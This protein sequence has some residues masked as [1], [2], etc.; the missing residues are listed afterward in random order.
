MSLFIRDWSVVS[1]LGIGRSEFQS[2]IEQRTEQQATDWTSHPTYPTL[3]ESFDKKKH[4]GKKGVRGMDQLGAYATTA[5]QLLSQ[6]TEALTDQDHSKVAVVLGTGTGS[7]KSQIEF[8][9]DLHV[10]ERVE[11]V[12]PI[13]FPQTVMNCAAGQVSIWH[14]FTGVNT[15]ISSGYQS[16]VTACEYANNLFGQ[17]RVDWALVGAAE[18]YSEYSRNMFPHASTHLHHDHPMGEGC[19]ML[20][21]SR[22]KQEHTV[23]EILGSQRFAWLAR[24]SSD[25]RS[26]TLSQLI[27]DALQKVAGSIPVNR[28]CFNAFSDD[29]HKVVQSL[30]QNNAVLNSAKTICSN[31]LLGDC[32]SSTA[33]FQVCLLLATYPPSE[34]ASIDLVLTNDVAGGVALTIIQQGVCE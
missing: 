33:I 8:I 26:A 6:Q 34:A 7:V 16:G 25:Q 24:Q 1:P 9:K 29:E 22:E 21:A 13:Q 10:Q 4:L 17:N 20:L 3:F 30:V 31:A 11:W 15:T 12:D 19:A 27:G 28:I 18:E 2:F 5:S 32:S 23:A 14:K